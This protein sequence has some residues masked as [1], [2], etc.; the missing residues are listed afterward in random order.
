MFKPRTIDSEPVLYEAAVKI[1]SRRAH[2]V[3]EMKKALIRRTAD[4]G[5]IQKVLA[6]LKQNGLIDDARYAKQFARQ[7]T[8]IRHQGKYRVARELRARGVPDHHIES[9]IAES[10]ANS[11]EAAMVRQRI[12]R[13]LKSLFAR[14]SPSL[15]S[16]HLPMG[17]R[18]LDQKKIASLY[19]TLLRAG[20]SSDT[21]RAELK[22]AT[23]DDLPDDPS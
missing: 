21:I 16:G 10:S 8:E 15:R 5:L 13:K 4:E 11:D 20:F 9:A 1:L 22:R 12:D 19:R 18:A 6:R 23:S 7:R 2:S 17:A 3:S 14:E